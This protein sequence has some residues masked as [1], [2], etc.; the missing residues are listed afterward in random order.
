[1]FTARYG[2]DILIRYSFVIKRLILNK[3]SLYLPPDTFRDT[4]AVANV[5]KGIKNMFVKSGFASL[6]YSLKLYNKTHGHMQSR[7]YSK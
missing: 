6:V 5:L 7:S 3:C 1:V 2:L 4:G